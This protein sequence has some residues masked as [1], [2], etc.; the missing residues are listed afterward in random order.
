MEI[1]FVVGLVI[2]MLA[3]CLQGAVVGAEMH[4]IESDTSKVKVGDS[5]KDCKDFAVPDGKHVRVLVM[6]DKITQI[7]EGRPVRG[8]GETH[9]GGWTRSD[10]EMSAGV[11][12]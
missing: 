12:Q 3:I 11:K 6:P 4:V 9:A 1:R 2:G 7:C 10:D 8:E 5:A